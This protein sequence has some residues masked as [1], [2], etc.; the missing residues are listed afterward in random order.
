[1]SSLCFAALILN[2]FHYRWRKKV[3][4]CWALA[5]TKIFRRRKQ[6]SSDPSNLESAFTQKV[7]LAAI[8]SHKTFGFEKLQT[9]QSI[10]YLHAA[11]SKNV[12][13]TASSATTSSTRMAGFPPLAQR[14][15][16]SLNLMPLLPK[17]RSGKEAFAVPGRNRPG[18]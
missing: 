4:K 12:L 9:L 14:S 15:N 8:H 18:A 17:S 6:P 7:P 3:K 2:N 1:M 5:I 10:E 11:F 13:S 16:C